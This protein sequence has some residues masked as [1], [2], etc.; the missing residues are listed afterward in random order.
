MEGLVEGKR[1]DSLVSPPALALLLILLPGVLLCLVTATP[2][3]R[4]RLLQIRDTRAQDGPK[5]AVPAMAM[6]GVT[7]HAAFLGAMFVV[8]G[9][10]LAIRPAYAWLIGTACLLEISV[11]VWLQ[12]RPDSRRHVWLWAYSAVVAVLFAVYAVYQTYFAPELF[13]ERTLDLASEVSPLAVVAVCGLVPML[14]ALVEQRRLRVYGDSAQTTAEWKNTLDAIGK[15]C[16]GAT[17]QLLLPL[18]NGHKTLF[19]L[20]RSWRSEEAVVRF[21]LPLITTALAAIAVFRVSAPTTPLLTA[22]G[23]WFGWAVLLVVLLLQFAFASAIARFAYYSRK[24]HRFLE[25]VAQ[26]LDDLPYG[27]VAPD[28]S[29]MSLFPTPPGLRHLSPL[30]RQD[31]TARNDLTQDL[32]STDHR[33]WFETDTWKFFRT[34]LTP[35]D[36]KTPFVRQLEALSVALVVRELLSRLSLYL[37]LAGPAV[38]L[39]IALQLTF[40][41]ERSHRLLALIWVD[42]AVGTAVAVWALVKE[43]RDTLISKLRGSEPG[44][45]DMNWDFIMKLLLYIA[46]PLLTL[47]IT[48]F[49]NVAGGLSGLLQALQPI[50][51]LPGS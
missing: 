38:V 17:D 24:T 2:A 14:F 26:S 47:F 5:T 28:L 6:S 36:T 41:F 50:Q 13:V 21:W 10:M 15:F 30:A 18:R 11:A 23:Q 51:H 46:L 7:I 33:R 25:C 43:D 44:E 42:V 34:Q 4:S 20:T 19:G 3:V 12:W 29:K 9:Y 27:D 32:K 1:Y 31:S 8:A 35:G 45:I 40:Y 22:E 48:Q 49:P 37:L 39:L 16:T